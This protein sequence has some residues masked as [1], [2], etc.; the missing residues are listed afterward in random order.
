MFVS[1]N[2][3]KMRIRRYHAAALALMGWYLMGPPF[4]RVAQTLRTDL[5]ISK[6]ENLAAINDARQGEFDSEKR[7]Q[8]YRDDFL[9]FLEQQKPGYRDNA[10]NRVAYQQTQLAECLSSDDSRLARPLA[11][12]K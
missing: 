5:P 11:H 7:C 3:H 12:S 4:D 1:Y 6:W 8:N 10:A 9:T 2:F